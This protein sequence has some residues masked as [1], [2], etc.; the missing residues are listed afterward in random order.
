MGMPIGLRG[1]SLNRGAGSDRRLLFR[2]PFDHLRAWLSETGAVGAVGGAC[3]RAR[4]H[5][6]LRPTRIMRFAGFE[7]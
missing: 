5:S 1:P 3:G 2:S 7:T 4:V 6:S